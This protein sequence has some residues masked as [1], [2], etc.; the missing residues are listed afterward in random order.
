MSWVHSEK[1][2]SQIS[3]F[4]SFPPSFP[5]SFLPPFLLLSFLSSL[6]PPSLA[7]PFLRSFLLFPAAHATYESSR[8]RD[9]VWPAAHLVKCNSGSV[10]HCPS[11]RSNPRYHNCATAGISRRPFF[12]FFFF[13]KPPIRKRNAKGAG[14]Q[15]CLWKPKERRQIHET[16]WGAVVEN[17]SSDPR[18]I[19]PAAG[20]SALED[21]LFFCEY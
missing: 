15:R 20:F 12:F 9:P 16:W 2:N 1:L 21:Q 5:P 6:L 18:A 17:G 13:F 10:T 8:A 14:Y 19:R 3:F 7:P 11:R 4:P